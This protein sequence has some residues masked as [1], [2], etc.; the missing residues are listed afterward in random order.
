[1]PVHAPQE[2]SRAPLAN[3]Q[4]S[5]NGTATPTLPAL[6]NSD[7][8]R[9]RR[10]VAN[11]VNGLRRQLVVALRRLPR[12]PHEGERGRRVGGEEVAVDVEEHAGDPRLRVAR[13]DRHPDA[14]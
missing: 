11:V 5:A 1:M 2:W 13:L 9:P 3:P 14:A 8:D 6:V 12:V 4:L 7:R 10:A